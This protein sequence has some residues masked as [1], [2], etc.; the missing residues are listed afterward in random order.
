MNETDYI[1]LRKIPY[2]ESSLIVS[3]ITPEYG[4]LDFVLR[5]GASVKNRMFP[6]AGLFREVH[7]EFKTKNDDFN[8]LVT[9]GKTELITN[10][11]SIAE[12]I[13]G[14]FAAC[15]LSPMLLANTAPTVP[16]PETYKALKYFLNAVL[17]GEKPEP[18]ETLVWLVLLYESGELPPQ[19]DRA[20]EFLISLLDRVSR[21]ED[22]PSKIPQSYWEK[23]A[24]WRKVVC[25]N[26]RK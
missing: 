25:R 6:V 22:L 13:P 7:V 9:A 2:R 15:E 19:E 16:V 14:Y 4:R 12:N 24:D 11:D 8:G 1:I 10:Y 3:G 26:L 5:G 17:K 18:Y 23:L 20:G 21:G